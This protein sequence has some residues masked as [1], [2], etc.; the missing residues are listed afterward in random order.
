[1]STFCSKWQWL[2]MWPQEKAQDLIKTDK[3]PYDWDLS[4]ALSS[5]PV[6]HSSAPANPPYPS[7]CHPQQ[8]HL[9]T[10]A[11]CFPLSWAVCLGYTWCMPTIS[12]ALYPNVTSSVFQMATSPLNFHTLFSSIPA[13]SVAR[14]PSNTLELTYWLCMSA[15][16][17]VLT[18]TLVSILPRM[19]A[20]VPTPGR[21][22]VTQGP[23]MH[24]WIQRRSTDPLSPQTPLRW[25]KDIKIRCIR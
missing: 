13:L 17:G 12:S 23:P 3:T 9:M 22:P 18:H 8:S 19:S 20:A 24:W 15:L 5:F 25:Q 10:F 16:H 21:V 2:P 4:P 14:T 1:M 7:P 6:P 11:G